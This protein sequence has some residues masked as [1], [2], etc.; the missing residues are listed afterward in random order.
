MTTERSYQK[1]KDICVI[2]S[3]GA[4]G[5]QGAQGAPVPEEIIESPEDFIF[6]N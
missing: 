6:I 4:Q 1:C 3:E 2:L 5:A